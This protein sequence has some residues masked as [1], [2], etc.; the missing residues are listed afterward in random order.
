MVTETTPQRRARPPY[1]V[2]AQ[3]VPGP[4]RRRQLVVVVSVLVAAFVLL[5]AQREDFRQP[6][7]DW[8]HTGSFDGEVRAVDGPIGYRSQPATVALGDGRVLIWG[9]R[10]INPASGR[11]YDPA[12]DQWE[13]VP[14]P[15]GEGR[16]DAVA[17]WTGREA[18]ILGGDTP[19]DPGGIAFDPAT[20]TWRQLPP[21]P[22]GL[23]NPRAV[24]VGGGVLVAGGWSGSGAEGPVSLWFDLA[25]ETWILVPAPVSVMHMVV[26]GARVLATGPQALTRGRQARSGWP[27]VAF[28]PA[29]L[30]WERV[31]APIETEWMALAVHDGAVTAVTLEGL[32]EPLRAYEWTGRAWDK[33]RETKSGA[34]PVSTIQ[35]IS[36]PP[37]TVWTGELLLVGGSQGL[38]SYD[39]STHHF[40]TRSDR[41]LVTFGGI[42]VWTGS[43]AVSLS[44]QSSKGWV[45][46]PGEELSISEGTYRGPALA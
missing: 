23:V 4:S 43:A 17:V 10:R 6:Y 30:Q 12:T 7:N 35:I 29:R 39:P 40:A 33:V 38:T 41:T 31:T 13:P 24:V 16:S 45:W 18:F 8:R 1:D 44:S 21:A 9:G 22:V 11:I 19:D 26:D 27:V 32:N 46:T 34:S 3:L 28:D 14:A 37:V 42:A 2:A 20:G 15:P 25:S 5:G 36:Y